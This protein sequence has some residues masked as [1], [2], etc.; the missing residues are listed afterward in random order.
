M[1]GLPRAAIVSPLRTPV[2]RFPGALAP[3]PV[4]RLAE[5][6]IRAVVARRGIDPGLIDD[7]V[8]AQTYA[9]SEAPCIGRRAGLAAVLERA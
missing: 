2:G 5:V 6:V 7:A 3:V 8:F 4:E 9:N 1:N